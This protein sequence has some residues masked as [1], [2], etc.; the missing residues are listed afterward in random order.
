MWTSEWKA[1]TTKDE[2]TKTQGLPPRFFLLSFMMMLLYNPMFK[3][4][5][6]CNQTCVVFNLV[7]VLQIFVEL[8]LLCWTGVSKKR[9]NPHMHP[10]VKQAH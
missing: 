3:R 4:V 8:V 10:F 9:S 1:T 5:S 2:A 6:C 7:F